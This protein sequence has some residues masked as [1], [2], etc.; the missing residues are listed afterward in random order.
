MRGD[1]D[2]TSVAMMACHAIQCR[3]RRLYRAFPGIKHA[4]GNL[5]CGHFLDERLADTRAGDRDGLIVRIGTD[6]AS[7]S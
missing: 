7:D 3:L 4:I 2:H 6:Q 5:V 1:D